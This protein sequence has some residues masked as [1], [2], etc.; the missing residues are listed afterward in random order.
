MCF[1]MCL[2]Y[3][4][5]LDGDY[6]Q[7]I[8]LLYCAVHPKQVSQYIFRIE[9]SLGGVSFYQNNMF[10]RF[11]CEVWDELQMPSVIG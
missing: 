8:S 10:I 6:Q 5:D 4:C 7:V 9:G 11:S 1:I 2:S 3:C